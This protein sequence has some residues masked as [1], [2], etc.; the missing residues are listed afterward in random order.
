[1]IEKDTIP[2]AE[3]LAQFEEKFIRCHDFS[4]ADGT[5]LQSDLQ[6]RYARL[7][8]LFGEPDSGDGYK[9]S[10]EWLFESD[11]GQVVTLY[12]W[13]STDLYDSDLPS[14]AEFRSR[15][16]AI[17]FHVGGNDLATAEQFVAWVE[18]QL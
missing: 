1:M 6:A 13:K 18:R 9:V 15:G 3:K 7:V 12:D 5:S 10:G 14:P 17:D 2:P 11:S 16:W 4:K 8:E